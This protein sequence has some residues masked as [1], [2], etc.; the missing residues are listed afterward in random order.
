MKWDVNCGVLLCSIVRCI[1]Q[2]IEVRAN[3]MFE[4]SQLDTSVLTY[5]SILVRIHTY[6]YVCASSVDNRSTVPNAS[7]SRSSSVTCKHYTGWQN[8]LAKYER[9]L[10]N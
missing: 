1:I 4:L 2:A 7:I 9:L 3:H 5:S 6:I 10:L 8:V